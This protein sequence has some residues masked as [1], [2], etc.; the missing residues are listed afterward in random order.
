VAT[1]RSLEHQAHTNPS[2]HS[3]VD[4]TYAVVR[5]AGETYLQIDTYGSSERK[6]LGKKSQSIR[7]PASLAPQVIGLLDQLS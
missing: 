2:E 4:A 6:L 7:I 3:E 1:I 5:V